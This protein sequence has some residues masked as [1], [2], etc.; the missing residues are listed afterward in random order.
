MKLENICKA[1]DIVNKTNWKPTD[2]E[3]IFTNPTSNKGLIC[4]IYK[5]FKKLIIRKPNNP[6][7][8]WYGSKQ[9]IHNREIS[10]G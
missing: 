9:R 8:M 7:K 4:K 6:I 2:W 5:E 1:K 3:K 10:N